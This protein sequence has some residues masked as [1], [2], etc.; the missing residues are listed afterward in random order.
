MDKL[1]MEGEVWFECAHKE[2]RYIPKLDKIGES[3]NG[4]I[5]HECQKVKVWQLPLSPSRAFKKNEPN[6]V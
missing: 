3:K 1:K 5:I 2:W 6:K 4:R